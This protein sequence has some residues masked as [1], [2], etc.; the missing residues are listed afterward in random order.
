MSNYEAVKEG[1]AVSDIAMVVIRTATKKYIVSTG[2]D[3]DFKVAVDQGQEKVLRKKNAI[4]AISKTDDLVKGYDVTFT[5]MLLHPE[6]LSLIEG[7]VATFQ[8]E[9]K[10]KDFAGPVAG[11]PVIREAVGIDVYCENVDTS[12][13]VK[14]Y[15][16]FSLENCKG[17]PTEFSLKDGEF[18]TPK[19]TV[20][21]RPSKG[22][23]SIK[24]ETV[25][26]LP[27]VGG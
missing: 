16:L 7:G 18:Y 25:E 12:S 23:P 5:D 21:S 11:A 1:F 17:K 20:E 6:I 13:T 3:A 22:S 19:Y 14:N 10:F 9:G 8:P 26:T 2:T 24:I 27:Q 4:L 15:M